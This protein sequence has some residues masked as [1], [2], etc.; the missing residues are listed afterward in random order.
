MLSTR[1]ANGALWSTLPAAFMTM[2]WRRWRIY[3]VVINGLT[4]DLWSG[5]WDC[6]YLN[7]SSCRGLGQLHSRMLHQVTTVDLM[8]ELVADWSAALG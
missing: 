6:D 5:V 7:S 2:F 3:N 1:L 8:F 4:M